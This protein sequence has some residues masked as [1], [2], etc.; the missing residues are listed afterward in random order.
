MY[1]YKM[2][3]KNKGSVNVITLPRAP[4][5]SVF[6]AVA[7]YLSFKVNNGLDFLSILAAL[8][9]PYIYIPYVLWKHG[10]DIIWTDSIHNEHLN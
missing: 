1:N 9:F 7:L 3:S 8:V 4:L 10:V 5:H 6:V 2:G